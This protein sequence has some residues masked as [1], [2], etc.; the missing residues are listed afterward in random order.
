MIT[1]TEYE[2]L[3]DDTL[4][5]IEE[6]IETAE[7]AI[8]TEL[9][10]NILTLTFPNSSKIIINKQPVQQEI[11]VAAKAGGFHFKYAT[12]RHQ[13]LTADGETL[14]ALLSRVCSAQLATPWE[15]TL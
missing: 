13:W 5:A 12:D 8:E 1:A 7:V 2:Q 15:F 4:L 9:N 14:S 11:W 3:A 6:N 10:G